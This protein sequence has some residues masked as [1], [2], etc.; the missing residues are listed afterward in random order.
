MANKIEFIVQEGGHEETSTNL[1]HG[2][3]G[4]MNTSSQAANCPAQPAF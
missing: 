3:Y 1:R 4:E 2:K